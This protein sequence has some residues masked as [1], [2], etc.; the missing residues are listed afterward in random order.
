MNVLVTIC[1]P[2]L[3]MSASFCSS[4]SRGNLEY[5]APDTAHIAAFRAQGD[6]HVSFQARWSDDSTDR[7]LPHERISRAQENE[8]RFQLRRAETA[9][10]FSKI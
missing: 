1:L 3:S 8:G 9:Q 10:L 4:I 2:L 6:I 5:L 7:A